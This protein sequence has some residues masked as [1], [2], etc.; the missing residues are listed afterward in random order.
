MKA[1]TR[2]LDEIT[3]NLHNTVSKNVAKYRKQAGMS[4]LQLALEIG[5]SGNAFIARAENRTNNAHFNVE[6]IYKIAE[7][8]NV[9]VCEF[10]EIKET[11]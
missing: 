5:L 8:L 7:V 1:N 4:Q 3:I 10:F 9:N 6:H 11:N 2:T